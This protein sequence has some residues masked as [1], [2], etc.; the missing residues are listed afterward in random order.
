MDLDIHRIAGTCFLIYCVIEVIN[1]L[2]KAS[3]LGFCD[4][5]IVLE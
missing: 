4:H 1:I 2:D 3:S 5:Y